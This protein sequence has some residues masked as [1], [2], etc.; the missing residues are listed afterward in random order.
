MLRDLGDFEITWLGVLKCHRRQGLMKRLLGEF[1]A[2]F[3][4]GASKCVFLEVH[5]ANKGAYNFYKCFGFK[6]VG[7]RLNYYSDGANALVMKWI[8]SGE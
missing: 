7:Q 2:C 5:E 1:V 6:Q 8:E 4:V 3:V